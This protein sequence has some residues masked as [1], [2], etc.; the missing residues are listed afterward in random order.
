M[1]PAAGGLVDIS[2]Q[3]PLQLRVPAH[4]GRGAL[5]GDGPAGG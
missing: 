4:A 3:D 1:T 5:A 2:V